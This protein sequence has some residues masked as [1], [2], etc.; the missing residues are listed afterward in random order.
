MHVCVYRSTTLITYSNIR[1]HSETGGS[2]VV[3]DNFNIID[4]CNNSNDLR[5]LVIVHTHRTPLP[6]QHAKCS[7]FVYSNE[8]SV[9]L[10]W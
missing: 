5:I 10:L 9:S 6:Q 1:N 7:S 4:S 2:P 3:L 8:L